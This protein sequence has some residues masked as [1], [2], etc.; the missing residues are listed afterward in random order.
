F[1]P[2]GVHG[3]MPA[4]APPQAGDPLGRNPLGVAG[5]RDAGLSTGEQAAAI[6]TW[7]RGV[8]LAWGQVE[9]GWRLAVPLRLRAWRLAAEVRLAEKAS[10]EAL[11]DVVKA[12]E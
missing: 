10:R 7:L 11:A 6:R 1:R 12:S 2:G 3:L 9:R 8:V 5:I 4:R